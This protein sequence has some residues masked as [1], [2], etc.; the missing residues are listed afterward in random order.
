MFSLQSTHSTAPYISRVKNHCKFVFW[1]ILDFSFLECKLSNKSYHT[2]QQQVFLQLCVSRFYH[3]HRF[4]FA[5]L[6]DTVHVFRNALDLMFWFLV[7]CGQS[8]FKCV[9]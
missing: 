4:L 7:S 3:E 9:V 6:I 8:N 5:L 2:K 1:Y